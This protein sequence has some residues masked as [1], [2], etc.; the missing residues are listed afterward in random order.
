MNISKLQYYAL[1]PQ[2]RETY[3][4]GGNIAAFLRES[5]LLDRNT[6]EVI[7]IAYDI[8]AGTYIEHLHKY[9]LMY[10]NY[11]TELAGYLEVYISKGES[12]LEVGC[13]EGTTT[14]GVYQK[15]VNKPSQILGFDISFSR[16]KFATAFW[17]H[18]YEKYT[19]VSGKPN[20][21]AKFFVADL[22]AIPLADKSIDVVFTSHSLEPNGGRE[23]EALRS[24]F[25]VASK[26]VL[27]FEPYFELASPE[28]QLR[29][30]SHGYIK[31]LPE[32]IAEAGGILKSVQKIESIQ[33][34]LNPTYC[35]DIEINSEPT[36]HSTIWV[37][38][39]TFNPL[40]EQDSCF[41]CQISGL[42]YPVIQNIP[43]LRPENAIVATRLL[44]TLNLD[45]QKLY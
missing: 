3:K 12:L 27:L 22:F 23:V 30:S 32:A 7:E 24:I 21:I 6:P 17:N 20:S 37:D 15:L 26:R 5:L 2:A 25:R 4:N 34:P 31:K 42:S 14:L 18:Q 35:F 28:G 39:I 44:D 33:N 8:Q 43:C 19:R 10:Q 16:V 1:V 45:A 29:M 9:P 41:Y 38:P 36:Q 13:G 40:S 11:Y